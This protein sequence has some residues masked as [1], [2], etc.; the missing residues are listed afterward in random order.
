MNI[1][2]IAFKII[3]NILACKTS[4]L[5][6]DDSL[7]KYYLDKTQKSFIKALAYG[8]FRYYFSLQ[9]ITSKYLKYKPKKQIQLLIYLATYQIIM[10]RQPSYAIINESVK[11]TSK[12]GNGWA[13]GLVNAVLRNVDREQEILKKELMSLQNSDAPEWL[14]NKL[15]KQYK[16]YPEIIFESNQHAPMFLRLN[17]TKEPQKVLEY[18]DNNN[19]KYSFKNLKNCVSLENPLDI[20]N[21]KLFQHGYFTVQDL[22]AQYAATILAPQEGDIVLDACAAPGGKSGHLLEVSPNIFLNSVELYPKRIKVLEKNL[23]RLNR[24]QKVNIIQADLSKKLDGEFDKILLDAPC[25]ATGVIRRNPDIKIL[26]SAQDVI[27]ICKIQKNILRCLWNN[28]LKEGGYLLYATC[29]I[30]L[31]ENEVQVA[32]FIKTHD[33]VEIIKINILEKYHL[34][35]GYQILPK[36][37]DG[38]YYCLFRKIKKN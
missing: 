17:A 23:E 38:F 29:S 19:I 6:I 5:L 14:L 2:L 12:I 18:F 3:S 21:N 15:K 4:L 28:N 34:K 26:R 9:K 25:S 16:R 8:F 37:G 30:L 20:E 32:N 35:Y 31:E 10:M 7:T 27:N 36:D 24:L 22:S 13:K 1:R 33:N 11:A